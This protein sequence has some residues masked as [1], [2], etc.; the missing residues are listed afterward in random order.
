MT[1]ACAWS[2]L[3]GGLVPMAVHQALQ[4][5]GARRAELVSGEINKL[6]EATQVLNSVLA[7]LNLPA[8]LE[9]AG[10]ELPD[11]I[12]SKAAAVRDAGGLTELS[13]LMAE[14]PDLLQRNKDILDEVRRSGK[15]F[16]H[17][18]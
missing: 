16:R 3:F 8:C 12:R 15:G 17:V 4:A 5:S 1:R 18:I 10:P 14:L 11:A 7:S 9:T 6:R 13:R 2:D